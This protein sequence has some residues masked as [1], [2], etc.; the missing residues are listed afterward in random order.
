DAVGV[1]DS[2]WWLYSPL[3]SQEAT[4]MVT[5]EATLGGRRLPARGL[6]GLR[7]GLHGRMSREFNSCRRFAVK[8]AE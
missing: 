1:L 4:A 7:Q 6:T 5:R 2:R 8:H 3:F